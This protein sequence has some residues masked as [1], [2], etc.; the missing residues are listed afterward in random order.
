MDG[1]ETHFHERCIHFLVGI[2]ADS[3]MQVQISK[4]KIDFFITLCG[5]MKSAGIGL[6]AKSRVPALVAGWAP[7]ISQRPG[8]V[9]DF[10]TL[11]MLPKLNFQQ[12]SPNPM[13][14]QP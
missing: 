12:R 6:P 8:S 9:P 4:L 11:E 13:A 14:L 5:V 1:F 2:P 7:R 10:L 3:E